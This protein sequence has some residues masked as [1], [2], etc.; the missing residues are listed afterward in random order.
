MDGFLATSTLAG[1]LLAG[2]DGMRRTLRASIGCVGIGLHSGAR[3]AMTLH[4]ASPG[5]GIRFRR[6]DI[7]LEIAARFDQVADTRLCTALGVSDRPAAE[8][9]GT[10]EHVLAAFV[11]AGVHD[12][13]V[14]L[15]GPEVPILDGS[16]RDILFLI[17]CVGTVANGLPVSVLEVLKPIRVSET[18]EDDSAWAELRPAPG[19]AGWSAAFEAALTIDFPNTAIGRQS[20]AVRL[21]P[22]TF[23][24]ALAE[25][26]TFTLAED[27]AR[28]RAAGLARGGSLA[29]AVVVDG[30]MVVNPT[31]LRSADEFVR[32]KLLDV[33][34]DLSLAGY[35]ISGRFSGYRSGHALNNRLLRALFADRSAW[36]VVEPDWSMAPVGRMPA[37]RGNAAARPPALATAA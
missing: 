37:L 17:D 16:A 36:R 9:I 27:V 21:T 22:Q 25:A 7:G 19:N 33:I 29:N 15:D 4:P 5:A 11:G 30:P 14:E 8:R 28:L 34:G 32:H 3:V 6:T 35:P 12:A 23:R 26:R 1:S 31:G 20:L 10:V 24:H 13:L 2:M 18:E